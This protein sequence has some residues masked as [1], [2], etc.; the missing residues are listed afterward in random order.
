MCVQAQDVASLTRIPGIGRKIAER[1]IVEMRDRVAD[2]RFLFQKKVELALQARYPRLFVPKYAMVTFHRVP[3]SVAHSRGS[4]QDRLLAELC[5]SVSRIEDLD[6]QKAE[7]LIH[8]N[9][10]PLED[11]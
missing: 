10:T 3:Y 11:L 7:M 1:L 4:I 5:D 6:W 8:R 2:P 9:L